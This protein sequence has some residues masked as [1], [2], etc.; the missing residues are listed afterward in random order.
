M[1]NNHATA[2]RPLTTTPQLAGRRARRAYDAHRINLST[3]Q[4]PALTTRDK[5]MGLPQIRGKL[6]R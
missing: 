5:P 1:L 2:A 3:I 6:C 4:F